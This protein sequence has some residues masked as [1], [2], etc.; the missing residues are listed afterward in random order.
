MSPTDAV[1]SKIIKGGYRSWFCMNWWVVNVLLGDIFL[2]VGEL[3]EFLV[4][5][6]ILISEV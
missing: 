2:I 3:F 5:L 1:L 4:V 6:S